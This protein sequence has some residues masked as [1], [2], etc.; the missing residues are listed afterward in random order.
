MIWEALFND[1]GGLFDYGKMIHRFIAPLT[2]ITI[3]KTS[4]LGCC[5]IWFEVTWQFQK[6][7][8]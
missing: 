4:L 7:L 3:Y 8:N 1:Y 5:E 2:C 6:P